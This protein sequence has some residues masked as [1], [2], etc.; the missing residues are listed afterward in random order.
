MLR[1]E[2]L[3]KNFP[4]EFDIFGKPKRFLK[5]VQDVSFQV[6]KGSVFSI[7]GESGSGKSTIAR[8]LSGIYNPSSGKIY[9]EGK[10]LKDAKRIKDIQIVF[11]DPE[12][13]LNPRKTISFIVEEG[14]LVHRS[15]SRLERKNS[16]RRYRICRVDVRY[17][18]KISSSTQWWSKTESCHC[19]QFGVKTQIAHTR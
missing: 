17:F 13:S 8:I 5:A 16:Q 1:V 9:Y 7:V 11:Q 14:L 12:T 4:V 15:A 10:I 3:S 18:E 19:P 2:N 6:E